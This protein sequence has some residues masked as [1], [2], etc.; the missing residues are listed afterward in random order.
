MTKI[1]YDF[2]ANNGDNIPYYLMK[3]DLVV[4]V[5][6]NPVLCRF[7]ADRFQPEIQS[8]RLS[9]ENCV[10]TAEDEDPEV[11]FY[12]HKSYHFH[13]QFPKPAP[14]FAKNFEKILLPSK[15]VIS[16]IKQYGSPHYIKI[17]IE[18]YDS[19]ILRALFDKGI[20]PPFISAE[21][22]S[23]EVFALLVSLGRYTAFK[24]VDGLTVS[25]VYSNRPILSGQNE[26]RYSFPFNS[27][28]PFGN[29]V[30][31]KW[32]NADNF[33]RLLAFEGLGWKDIHATNQE[34]ADPSA[35]PSVRAY[36]KRLATDKIKALITASATLGSPRW[37]QRRGW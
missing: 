34:K 19:Q 29:D 30:D 13:S 35:S 9:I 20:Y 18:R 26:V 37:T 36:F 28:G 32:M 12:I 10:L 27:A 7:I 33:F 16:I 14:R 4:A 8:E 21:S 3:S 5:E 31:G 2:G 17:D 25:Q 6:A 22:H 15:S 1:I 24:L 23:I 11:A